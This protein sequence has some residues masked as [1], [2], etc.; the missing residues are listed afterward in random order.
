M[1]TVVIGT[2]DL[3]RESK[4]AFLE[5]IGDTQGYLKSLPGFL[6]DYLCEGA[7]DEGSRC[8]IATIA[9]WEDEKAYENA[10]A[11]VAAWNRERGVDAQALAR[12]LGV[13]GQRVAY[14]RVS[15]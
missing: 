12:D 5:L 11:A 6:E 7:D 2:Y 10:V 14:K 4:E 13:V 3:P 1:Q 8:Q 15:V 9:F